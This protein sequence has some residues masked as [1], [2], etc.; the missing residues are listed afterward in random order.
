MYDLLYNTGT[1]G[2]TECNLSS[3]L[4]LYGSKKLCTE[5]QNSHPEAEGIWVESNDLFYL[6]KVSC[7]EQSVN[8]WLK[9]YTLYV[10][11]YPQ[12]NLTKACPRLFI[13]TIPNCIYLWKKKDKMFP[14]NPYLKY[15]E[16]CTS[17]CFDCSLVS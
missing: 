15:Q 13:K 5:S 14:L 8:T 2:A 4:H 11:L 3:N 7:Y 17:D 9:C 10:I 16:T 12:S 1:L 6:L